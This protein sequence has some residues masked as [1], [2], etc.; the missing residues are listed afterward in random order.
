MC[1]AEYL[2]QY[3]NLKQ[4]SKHYEKMKGMIVSFN[5]IILTKVKV[6]SLNDGDLP[7]RALN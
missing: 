3:T 6:Q 5:T 7:A 1:D 4:W 2:N